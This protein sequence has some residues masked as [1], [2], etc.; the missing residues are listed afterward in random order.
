[1]FSRRQGTAPARLTMSIYDCRVQR[2]DLQTLIDLKGQA[3]DV[4][5]RLQ[6]LG[7][8]DPPVQRVSA[9]GSLRLLRPAPWHWLL[10]APLEQEDAL[11]NCLLK[12]A[13]SADDTLIVPVSDAYT[14]FALQ[15]GEAR[16]LMAVA[17][18]LDLDPNVFAADGATFTEAFGLKAL[19]W[20]SVDGFELAVERSYGPMVA[21]WLARIQGGG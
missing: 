21:D 2:M 18:P 11:L 7:L 15:G 19:L 20:R 14:W 8:A 10:R 17:C 16:E 4:L 1:M 6:S 3:N 5:P 13:P 9:S 12:H